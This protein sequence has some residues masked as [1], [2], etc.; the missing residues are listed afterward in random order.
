[1]IMGGFLCWDFVVDDGCVRR[2]VNALSFVVLLRDLR[3]LCWF[4]VGECLWFRWFGCYLV[5]L[6]K[7]NDC[8]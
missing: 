4:W 8:Y 5:C 3:F 2:L 1:M 6:F 7:G